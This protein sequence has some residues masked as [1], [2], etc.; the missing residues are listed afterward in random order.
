MIRRKNKGLKRLAGDAAT[1]IVDGVVHFWNAGKEKIVQRARQM[2]VIGT[3][4]D[5]ENLAL[6]YNFFDFN[7]DKA[8]ISADGGE[9]KSVAQ[10]Q[11]ESGMHEIKAQLL[12]GNMA[13][14]RDKSFHTAH[15][16][17]KKGDM[18]DHLISFDGGRD[19]NFMEIARKHQNDP[20]DMKTVALVQKNFNVKI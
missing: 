12:N 19:L 5:L 18:Q 1:Y 8:T 2:L 7:F 14:F 16:K 6:T 9:F 15:L 17:L 10:W 20:V 4:R 11:K 3:E 13:Y